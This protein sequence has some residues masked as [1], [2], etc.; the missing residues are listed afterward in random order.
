MSSSLYCCLNAGHTE[1]N[2]A[3][4]LSVFEDFALP[5]SRPLQMLYLALNRSSYPVVHRNFLADVTPF[6]VH[7]IE[8]FDFSK[9]LKQ[10]TVIIQTARKLKHFSD[11]RSVH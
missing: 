2:E 6:Y 4:T 3:S 8:R 9:W 11:H 10:S 1:F 5:H 7:L